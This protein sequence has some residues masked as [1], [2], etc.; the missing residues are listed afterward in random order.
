MIKLDRITI[1]KPIKNLVDKELVKKIQRNISEGICFLY[2]IENKKEIK[3][4]IKKIIY[5]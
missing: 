3:D 5:K 4:K 1:Q 2:L